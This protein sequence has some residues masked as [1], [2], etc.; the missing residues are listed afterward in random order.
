MHAYI[1]QRHMYMYVGISDICRYV[2][3]A[4]GIKIDRIYVGIQRRMPVG[5]T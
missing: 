4:N 5:C 2:R 3:E 1:Q